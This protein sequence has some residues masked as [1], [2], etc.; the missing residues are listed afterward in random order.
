MASKLPNTY[1]KVNVIIYE[2]LGSMPQYMALCV[3]EFVSLCVEKFVYATSK[4][5]RMKF[6]ML[7]VLTNIRLTKGLWAMP[8]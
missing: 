7:T 1:I 4:Q 3:C 5:G 6:G 8:H 2:F